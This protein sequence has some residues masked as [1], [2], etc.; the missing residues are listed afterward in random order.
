MRARA[1]VQLIWGCLLALLGGCP[2]NDYPSLPH[3]DVAYGSPTAPRTC[4][5]CHRGR[6]R[7]DSFDQQA[8]LHCHEPIAIQLRE[9]KG[10]HGAIIAANGT[11]RCASCHDEH[12]GALWPARLVVWPASKQAAFASEHGRATGFELDGRHRTT[13]C[14]RCH[15]RSR[16]S[17]LST[18]TG[19]SSPCQSCHL[20]QSNHGP[21]RSALTDCARCHTTQS[22]TKVQTPLRF[23]HDRDT[24]YPLRGGH[25]HAQ[26]SCQRCHAKVS[27]PGAAKNL[28]A[29]AGPLFALP[30]ERFHDCQPCHEAR[31][32]HGGSFGPRLCKSCHSEERG[33]AARAFRHGEEAG[34]P[35]L[36][37]HATAR[38]ADCHRSEQRNLPQSACGDCHSHNNVHG[39]RFERQGDCNTCHSP[40]DWIDNVFDHQTRTGFPLDNSH[41]A[42]SLGECLKCHRRPK[43]SPSGFESLH[44]LT[45]SPAQKGSH[46]LRID[47]RSCHAHKQQHE[48]SRTPEQ[49]TRPCLSCHERPGNSR[50]ARALLAPSDKSDPKD[51]RLSW[52]GHGPGKPFRLFGGHSISSLDTCQACHS[53]SKSGFAK[54]PT[55]CV[56]CHKANDAHAASLGDCGRCH[57]P[58]ANTWQR[59]PRLNHDS[60][61]ALQGRHTAAACAGC[62]PSDDPAKQYRGRPTQCGASECHQ[63]KDTLHKGSRGSDCGSTGCHSPRHDGWKIPKFHDSVPPAAEATD[64]AA[65]GR[66]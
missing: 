18:F 4:S 40:T 49:R 20:A 21:L 50:L 33:W 38:C 30:A 23:Q 29:T 62:H 64:A 48:N 17:G 42:N 37:R 15:D 41:T 14:V 31:N 11:P 7:V 44:L 63:R 3:R 10:H 56:A 61:F 36:G 65:R 60:V 35:L 43:N 59:T 25:A 5:S 8:C 66:K 45:G 51:D 16:P 19:L 24:P 1:A 54:L 13:P 52:F 32:P 58:A 12:R 2:Y 6:P 39:K 9:R 28:P 55:D 22:W 26:D 27:R 47:C 57:D 34:F 53:N 46:V